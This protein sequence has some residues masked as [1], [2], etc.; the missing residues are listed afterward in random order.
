MS[1]ATY[2]TK[3]YRERGGDRIVFKG[4]GGYAQFYE[5]DFTAEELRGLAR[6]TRAVV[7]MNSAGAMSGA[8]QP[9]LPSEYGLIIL[10]FAEAASNASARMFSCLSG[11]QCIIVGRGGASTASIYIYFSGHASGINSAGCI[12]PYSGA[13]SGIHF[14]W[15]AAGSSP[16][17]H[18]IA[19]P[20][21]DWAVADWSG[22]VLFA[23]A[24]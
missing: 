10:S 16:R 13:I 18:L 4:G 5:T 19:G 21:G 6:Q 15:S 8:A 17:V 3:V 20:T 2:Q 7:I 23:S 9:V 14:Q 1:D 12:G 24:S 11:Q 22:V